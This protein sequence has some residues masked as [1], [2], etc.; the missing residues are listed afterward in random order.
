M[1]I[2]PFS[3]SDAVLLS[4]LGLLGWK[5]L[6]NWIGGSPLDIIPGP[7][8]GSIITGNMRQLLNRHG[9]KHITALEEDYGTVAK[10]WTMF[11]GRG[12]F[13]YDPKALNH[14]VVKEQHIYEPA[15]WFSRSLGITLGNGLFGSRGE[16]HRRQRKLLNPAFSNIHLRS[17]APIFYS[18]AH[19]LQ[20]ALSAQVEEGPKDLDMVSWTSRA[21]L[22]LIGQGGLGH[23]FDSLTKD[24]PNPYGKAL[25]D[26][27]PTYFSIQVFRVLAHRLEKLG[28]R[29][30]RRWV[31]DH[32]P[33]RGVQKM[34]DI[35]D[36]MDKHSREIFKQKKE[37]L[38]AGDDA[39]KTQVGE[40]KDIMSILLR[41]NMAA[42]EEDRLL[43][44]E[45]IAQIST[46]TFA[47]TDT[48]SNAL[49]QILLLLVQ[50]PHVQDN[51]RKEIREARSSVGEDIPYDQLMTL[52]YLDAVCRETLRLYAPATVYVRETS[53]DTVMPLSYPVRST[54]GAIMSE[55]PVP[56]GTMVMIGVRA[57]NTT[58]LLWG[59]D[60]KE[61]K[62]ERW[63]KPLPVKVTEAHLPGA[64]SN[65][66]TFGGGSRACIG[67]KFSEV[68]MK[69]MLVVL[70]EKF[71]FSEAENGKDIIWNVAAVRYPTLGN[72]PEPEC[73][74]KVELL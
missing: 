27:S 72:K 3:I 65:L 39:L 22:E 5:L 25:K 54:T 17:M 69:I 50:H 1:A 58:K 11:G 10:F 34:K 15:R 66:M 29:S 38:A 45:L 62:P 57:A 67:Y 43:E 64:L 70:L 21:A 31:V 4:A 42:S 48:T 23:S 68:E 18:V 53:S 61:W 16:H 7:K 20:D 19:S 32:T 28:P 73:P 12:L 41:A 24:T 52:P 60:A 6:W 8:S 9:W 51:L 36:T 63:L 59:E 74:I 33:I 49:A 2:L 13:V 37:A 14:I 30:F 46:F 47:G 56:K 35:T 55:I 44:E 26:F 40:G 71:H